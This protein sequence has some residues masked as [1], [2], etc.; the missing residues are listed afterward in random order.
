VGL[1]GL[2]ESSVVAAELG[3][4]AI[5]S[6]LDFLTSDDDFIMEEVAASFCCFLFSIARASL[7]KYG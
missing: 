5:V 4:K 3:W 1:V 2:S 7:N 6:V